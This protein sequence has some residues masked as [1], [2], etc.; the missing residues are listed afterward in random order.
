[1]R[2]VTRIGRLNKIKKDRLSL[3]LICALSL[4]LLIGACSRSSSAPS[5]ASG[6]ETS[7]WTSLGT[8]QSPA[9][10]DTGSISHG[11]T[12]SDYNPEATFPGTVTLPQQFITLPDGTKLAAVVTLPADSNGDAVQGPFPAILVQTSYNASIGTISS[13]FFSQADPYIG[14]HGYATVIVDV[15]GSGSSTGEWSAFGEAEQA[16]S[17]NVVDWVTQQSWSNG[18]VGLFGPSYMGITTV[19]TAAQNHP[20]V[21]AAFAVVPMGDAYRDIVFTGGQ[22]NTLFIPYWMSLVGALSLVNTQPL[23]D[24]STALGTTLSH[25]LNVIVGFQVP[26]LLQS[27][28]GDPSVAYDGDFWGTRSPLEYASKITVPTFVVGGEHDIFQRGEPLTY[29]QIK[30]HA[31]TKLLIGP[32]THGTAVVGSGLPVDGVP[33]LN[34]IELRWFDQYLKGFKLGAEKLPNVTQY[35]LGVGHYVTAD[36]WPHPRATAQRLFFHADKSLSETAP[37][38]DESS[39]VV[40]Q[41]P[42]NGICSI[43][44]VQW[45]GGAV[46]GDLL[47]LPC[48]TD[49][50]TAEILD[51]KYE[52]LPMAS[53]YYVNGPIEVDVWMSTTASDAGLSVRIDDVDPSGNA[54]AITNGIQTASLRAVDVTKSRTLNGQMIQPW[55]PYTPDSVQ[56]VGSGNKVMVPVEIFPTSAMIAKGHK[57]RVAVGSS[58]LPQG[59]P[60]V[61]TLLQSLAG[62]LT[63]YSDAAHPSSVVLPVVPASELSR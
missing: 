58:D 29:E 27:Y 20:A 14:E 8:R 40:A 15:R 38:V 11:T 33:A 59:V 35:V 24:P 13:Q 22:A 12:W 9:V 57:L 61:P 1:M 54:T 52:T 19:L 55:H 28:L 3:P 26:T 53:D 39:N 60:P 30:T 7:Q 49:D 47:P 4:L 10:A 63:I 25:V 16:D 41:E 46:S 42:I 21:K 50:N 34:H 36:D 6:H 31:T 62:V 48:F 37:A 45:L 23:N 32:W 18:R 43:S 44:T 56:S 17:M 5:G 51:V 2:V